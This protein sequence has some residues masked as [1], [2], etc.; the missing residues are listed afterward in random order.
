MLPL[1]LLLMFGGFEAGAY[2][3]TEQKVI[4]AVREGA[5]YAGRQTF[6]SFPCGG[7]INSAVEDN[8]QNV[9][10]TGTPTGT[11]ARVPGMEQDD[12][13]VTF[14][15]DASWTGQGIFAGTSG[16]APIV[17]VSATSGYPSLFGSLG[18]FDNSFNVGARAEAVVNGI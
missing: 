13:T 8:I 6:A 10:L 12:V 3:Y 7:S 16:G 9:T 15:C 11:I 1:L 17:L 18:V 5:R 4:K 2:F 14:R